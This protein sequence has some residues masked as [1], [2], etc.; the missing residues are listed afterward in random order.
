MLIPGIADG[1]SIRKH[2]RRA[3]IDRGNERAEPARREIAGLREPGGP[4]EAP[5]MWIN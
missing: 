2:G 4:R 5:V 3:A 1:C